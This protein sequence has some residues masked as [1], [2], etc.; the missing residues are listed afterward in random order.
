[1]NDMPFRSATELVGQIK[2]RQISARALLEIYLARVD[3]F[4]PTLN[5]IV[6]QQH[7][8]ALARADAADAALARGED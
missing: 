3:Q 8:L 7:D 4:N 1:M 5:A 6:V 2:S